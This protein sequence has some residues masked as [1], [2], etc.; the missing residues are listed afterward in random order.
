MRPQYTDAQRMWVAQERPVGRHAQQITQ[1]LT[2]YVNPQLHAYES[3]AT[4]ATA[5]SEFEL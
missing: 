2:F 3:L 1:E 5:I 4:V